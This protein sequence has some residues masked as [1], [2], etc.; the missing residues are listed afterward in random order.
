MED[1]TPALIPQRTMEE[2]HLPSFKESIEAGALTVMV[3]MGR[4]MVSP[5]MLMLFAF[6][7][8]KEKWG[9]AGFAVSDWED[10]IKLRKEH[11]TAATLKDGI[12]SAINL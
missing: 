1:R 7:G 6:G 9:F 12:A 3:N 8:L 11:K 2:Y 4:S 10:F 5:D